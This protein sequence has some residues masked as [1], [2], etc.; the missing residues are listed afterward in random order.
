MKY[1]KMFPPFWICV[2]LFVDFFVDIVFLFGAPDVLVAITII[3]NYYN[4]NILHWILLSHENLF[5]I[6]VTSTNL[7]DFL[8]SKKIKLVCNL[9]NIYILW[10]YIYIYIYVCIYVIRKTC[11]DTILYNW[12]YSTFKLT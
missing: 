5:K 10:T 7:E 11:N 4:N 8:I 1:K 12:K 2:E 6:D 9:S 3:N